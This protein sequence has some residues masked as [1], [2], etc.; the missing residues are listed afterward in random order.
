MR[1]M[2]CRPGIA[3]NQV[4]CGSFSVVSK[5][6]NERSSAQNEPRMS[7]RKT[8]EV[9]AQG[10]LKDLARVQAFLDQ[11]AVDLV[12]LKSILERHSLMINWLSFCSKAGIENPL[13]TT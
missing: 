2:R 11:E 8:I 9:V 1:V 10:R 6:A 13:P 3:Q 12:A 7:L 4:A 5:Y